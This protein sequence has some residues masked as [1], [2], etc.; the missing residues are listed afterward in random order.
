MTTTDPRPPTAVVT[1]RT[2][3]FVPGHRPDRFGKAAAAGADAIVLDLEDAV[4]GEDKL[5][6][7]RNVRQWRDQGGPGFVRVNSRTTRWYGDDVASLGGPTTVLLPKATSRDDIDDLWSRL[8][9]GSWIVPILETAQ[10]IVNATAIAAAPG[11][12]RLAFGNGD[13]AAELGVAHT[14][15]AA[16]AAARCAVVLASAA[17][18]IA[19]PLD[20]VTTALDNDAVLVAD[21]RHARELGYTGRLCIHPRQIDAIHRELAPTSEEIQWARA[22]L[23]GA[24]DSA[25]V[26]AGGMVD[27]PILERA[28]RLL[29]DAAPAPADIMHPA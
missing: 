12:A 14:S 4:A 7:R 22:V 21:T 19:S 24:G 2:I 27:Q 8:A 17:A 1:A 15:H 28:Q 25:T 18:G 9:P 5:V 20:G 3:L 13:L 23:D 16:L 11:V 10:G 29:A 6:A 26:V